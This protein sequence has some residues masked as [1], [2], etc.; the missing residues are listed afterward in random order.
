MI[1]FRYALQFRAVATLSLALIATT[2]HGGMVDE[3]FR[4]AKIVDELIPTPPFELLDVEFEFGKVNISGELAP[5]DVRNR[6]KVSWSRAKDDE[7]YSL[8]MTDV[9]RYH[10]EWLHWHV[11]NIPG[12]NVEQGQ[13][14][15]SF[16]PSAP[17]KGT[18]EHRYALLMYKQ[19]GKI[20]FNGHVLIPTFQ[21]NGRDSFSTRVFADKNQ[22]GAP[23]AGNFYVASWD[24][25][26]DELNAL[27]EKYN[28]RQA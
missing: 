19:Q 7:F 28:K 12:D 22:L 23:V 26:V 11:S 21:M 24:E 27:I 25:S 8:I 16:F 13:T 9:G 20:D 10:V 17:P 14:L 4:N 18:G 3:A 6:P 1:Q 15:T 2:V 5:K